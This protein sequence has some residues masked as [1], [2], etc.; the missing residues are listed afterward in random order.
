MKLLYSLCLLFTIQLVQ[1][2][3]DPEPLNATLI[4]HVPIGE[5]GNDIW[6]YVDSTGTEYAIMGGASNTHIW[7]L[8]D[9]ANPI[10]R[11]QI[12]GTTT[13]WRDMKVWNDHIYVTTDNTFSNMVYDGYLIVDMSMAPDSISYEFKKPTFDFAGEEQELGACHNIY[14]DEA[15]YAYLAGCNVG[16]GGIIILDLNEDPKNPKYVGNVDARY[17]HDVYVKDTLMYTSDIYDGIFSVYNIKDRSN[18]VYL[19]GESTSSDFTH[20]AWLSDDRDFLFTT[21]ERADGY[22]DAFN[23]GDLNNIEKVDRFQ[24]L[25]SKGNGVIPHNTHYLNGFLVTSW[26][27]D[28]LVVIDGNKPDNLIEVARYDTWHGAHGGFNGCWGAYPF[29]PSGKMLASDIQSGL[30]IVDVDFKRAAYLEGKISDPN[31]DPLVNAKVTILSDEI[32]EGIS[33]PAGDYKTGQATAG[34]FDV[35]VTHAIFDTVRTEAILVN[36]EVTILDVTMGLPSSVVDID[37]EAKIVI[38]PNPAQDYIQINTDFEQPKRVMVIDAMG[39]TIID[40]AYTPTLD[41]SNWP[42][43]LY[44][45]QLMNDKTLTAPVTLVKS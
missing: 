16:R 35:I 43:G 1:A 24:P 27:T 15:G 11:A 6:G 20:N 23:I 39:K 41:S 21:D 44:F 45:I 37:T 3:P 36:G 9:M 38:A 12:P 34:T 10:K 31:G 28:G 22:V 7:S 5:N 25:D 13:I 33:N 18:P 42:A 14:I 2:Q 29:L 26:Y 19:G 40:Q 32:N 30:Y 4:A 17:A 8:E